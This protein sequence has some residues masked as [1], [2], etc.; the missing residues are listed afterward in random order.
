MMLLLNLKIIANDILE[1]NAAK[2]PT[3]NKVYQSYKKFKEEVLLIIK[4]QKMRLLRQETISVK[5]LTFKSLG[6]SQLSRNLSEHEGSTSSRI[7][8][9]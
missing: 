1:E 6:V 8:S 3:V 5:E 7:F 4:S 9:K 2:D